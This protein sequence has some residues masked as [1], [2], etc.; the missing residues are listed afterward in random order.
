MALAEYKGVLLF[1]C[2][3]SNQNRTAQEMLPTGASSARCEVAKGVVG[4]VHW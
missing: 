3:R 2:R 4:I 1:D